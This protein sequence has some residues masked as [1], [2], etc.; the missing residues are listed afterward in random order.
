M[1][2]THTQMETNINI[3]IQENL[4]TQSRIHRE[5]ITI[6]EIRNHSNTHTHTHTHT[7]T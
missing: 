5:K 7:H 1:N 2:S 4:K 6:S 3:Y